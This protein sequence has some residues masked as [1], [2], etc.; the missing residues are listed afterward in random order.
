MPYKQEVKT[1]LKR[2]CQISPAQGTQG[3]Q[4]CALLKQGGNGKWA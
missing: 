4:I 3:S 2:R 1:D